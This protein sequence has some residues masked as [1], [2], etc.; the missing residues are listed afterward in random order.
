MTAGVSSGARMT[1]EPKTGASAGGSDVN[2]DLPAKTDRTDPRAWLPDVLTRIAGL[3]STLNGY[4]NSCREAGHHRRGEGSRPGRGPHRRLAFRRRGCA[5]VDAPNRRPSDLRRSKTGSNAVRPGGQK[6]INPTESGPPA[7]LI[8]THPALRVRAH[9]P[10]CQG[11]AERRF[12][13]AAFAAYNA[14]STRSIHVSRS[15][16]GAY[17]AKPRLT[18]IEAP[19]G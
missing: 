7:A 10:G 5:Q 15:S 1:A 8:G 11:R 16:A 14:R 9:E 2:A 12:R 17:W 6:A 18:V 13:P 19:A 3:L 4:P